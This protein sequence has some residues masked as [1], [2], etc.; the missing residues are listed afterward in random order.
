[1]PVAVP[2]T[3]RSLAPQPSLITPDLWSSEVIP[4]LPPDLESQAHTLHALQRHRAFACASDLLRALLAYVLG[5][6]SFAS[7]GA[8]AV[9]QGIADIGPTAWRKRL[10]RANPWLAWLLSTLLAYAPAT[11]PLARGRRV[12]L[13][14]ATRL[15]QWRGTGDDW[16]VHL[17]YDLSMGQMDHVVV[18]NRQGAERLEHAALRPGDLCV[19]DAGFGIRASVA[20]LYAHHADGMLR[21]YPPNFA[22]EDAIGQPIDLAAW[23][24]APGGAMRDLA[25]WCRHGQQRY[26]MR[27]LALTLP[28]EIAAA[29]RRRKLK[30]ARGCPQGERPPA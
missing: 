18:T 3:R 8:W 15:R 12:R 16:R 28:A 11:L 19:A 10:G 6:P 5:H 1:M 27:L 17:S 25:C 7:L 22:V 20:T 14:D 21:V 9:I 24:Q 4:R 13:V 30:E 26:P 23:A 2:H 29:K